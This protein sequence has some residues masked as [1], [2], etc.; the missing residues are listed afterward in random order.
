MQLTASFYCG[1]AANASRHCYTKN[2]VA[3]AFVQRKNSP[4]YNLQ[5]DGIKLVVAYV[6]PKSLLSQ[7]AEQL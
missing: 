5:H 1:N 6:K 4:F 3:L 7:L 2:N